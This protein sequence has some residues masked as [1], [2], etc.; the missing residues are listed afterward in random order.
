VKD[1]EADFSKYT[2]EQI[3][4]ALGRIDREKYPLNYANLL[5]AQRA[6]PELP[7]DR[8]AIEERD[9]A[10]LLEQVASGHVWISAPALATFWLPCLSRAVV[11]GEHLEVR[12]F[13]SREKVPLTEVVRVRWYDAQRTENW[14]L[15]LIELRGGSRIRL[16]PWSRAVMSAFASHVGRLKGGVDVADPNYQSNF[17]IGAPDA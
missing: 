14:H 6:L 12:G 4:R 10:R 8:A 13:F 5:A 2:H 9:Y 15:A 7:M 1:G 3:A 17:S 16:L 11:R